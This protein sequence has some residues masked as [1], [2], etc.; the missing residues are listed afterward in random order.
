[1]PETPP[2]LNLLRSSLAQALRK[3]QTGAAQTALWA[4]LEHLIRF[5]AGLSLEVLEAEGLL[6]VEQLARL[7]RQSGPLEGCTQV[8]TGALGAL[9][10]PRT[11]RGER[12]RAVFFG[13]DGPLH[14]RWL[15]LTGPDLSQAPLHAVAPSQLAL[16][17]YSPILASWL[18]AA[19][20]LFDDERFTLNRE[21]DLTL[22][23]GPPPPPE[24]DMH[25]LFFQR[26]DEALS[27]NLFE[28]AE[29]EYS[30]VLALE[31]TPAAF[32]G[33]GRARSCLGRYA[34]AEEDL[35]GADDS[36]SLFFRACN[37]RQ[38]GSLE[39]ALDDVEL[40]LQRTLDLSLRAALE[41]ER[42]A[43]LQQ[44]KQ[45]AMAAYKC[46]CDLYGEVA[47]RD[48]TTR[49]E[50]ELACALVEK[51]F[52]ADPT[53]KDYRARTER[54]QA[55]AIFKKLKKR[56]PLFSM[57]IELLRYVMERRDPWGRPDRDLLSVERDLRSIRVLL[58][59]LP[60]SQEMILLQKRF[61]ELALERLQTDTLPE[62]FAAQLFGLFADLAAS[63]GRDDDRRWQAEYWLDLADAF[64]N[65]DHRMRSLIL[66]CS[67]L[68]L[69]NRPEDA[70]MLVALLNQLGEELPS[71]LPTSGLDMLGASFN[72]VRAQLQRWG[73][74]E[75][76][77]A[78]VQNMADRW[79]A[80]PA[81]LPGRAG[82]GRQVLNELA[83]RKTQN[84]EID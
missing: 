31:N 12:L 47:G 59:L 13:Y 66:A 32:F 23:E 54:N 27:R 7:R 11:P 24:V 26:A 84:V 61:L 51:A 76:Y 64:R 36:R 14:T 21:L 45:P 68:Q 49:A 56:E 55:V 8:L 60:R 6:G 50:V 5:F 82:V 81:T 1:M 62:T 20:H 19:G 72:T 37:R 78:S 34:E 69:S 83:G 40:A 17:E 3:E 65:H 57:D 43:I 29:Q 44:M 28:I 35:R 77:R 30:R 75:A 10:K 58:E 70:L 73:N 33:R 52:L 25:T 22:P 48:K 2:Q 38:A 9:S 42:G 71:G 74:D 16:S 63:S 15:R 80:L 46:A 18:E 41:M 67:S 39:P 79:R 4:T 53:F